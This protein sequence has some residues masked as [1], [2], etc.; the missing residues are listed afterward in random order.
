MLSFWSTVGT[1]AVN[2]SYAIDRAFWGFT[3]F[4]FHIIR[5]VSPMQI[6]VSHILIT[7]AGS[8]HVDGVVA[9]SRDEALQRAADVLFRA[10]KGEDFEALAREYSDDPTTAKKGGRMPLIEHGMMVPQFE[11]AAFS[12]K[13]GQ[14]SDIVETEFGFHVIKRLY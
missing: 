2:V 1:N 10:R 3:P 6:R 9:R 14:I 11:E 8:Q 5:R 12:L 7:F 4:G 13:P